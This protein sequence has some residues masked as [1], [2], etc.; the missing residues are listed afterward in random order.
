MTRTVAGDDIVSRS[1]NIGRGNWAASE[2][3]PHRP[4][5]WPLRPIHPPPDRSACARVRRCRA[6]SH[7]EGT[8]PPGLE[9]DAPEPR[10]VEPPEQGR[11]LA[12]PQVSGTSGPEA[13]DRLERAVRA[14]P[15]V[16]PGGA[17]AADA[18]V[19]EREVEPDGVGR[20]ERAQTPRH[21]LGRAPGEV[22]APREP[23]EAADAVHVRVERHDQRAARHVPEA[24]VDPVGAAHHPAQE[25][26]EPLAGAPARGVREEVLEPPRRAALPEQWSEIG[27]AQLV[28]E[29]AQRDPQRPRRPPPRGEERAQ[30]SV[31]AHDAA[32]AVE[33]AGNVARSRHP[34]GEIGAAP[35]QLGGRGVARGGTRRRT[36]C[37]Q[38]RGEPGLE[39]V[40]APV[41]ERGAEQ[42]GHLDVERIRVT[43]H[44]LDRIAPQP[45]GRVGAP[46]QFLQRGPDQRGAL[47]LRGLRH[48]DSSSRTCVSSGRISFSQ[49]SLTAAGLPGMANT[50]SPL[51]SWPASARDSMAALPI[52]SYESTRNSSPNP[53]SGRTTARERASKVESRLDRPVPPVTS[54]NCAPEACARSSSAAMR[55]GS[56]G[57]IAEPVTACPAAASC[58]RRMRPPSSVASVRESEQ[59]TTDSLALRGARA[60]CAPGTPGRSCPCSCPCPWSCSCPCPCFCPT[61]SSSRSS[62]RPPS[63]RTGKARWSWHSRGIVTLRPVPSSKQYSWHGQTTARLRAS[64]QPPERRHPAW[65]HESSIAVTRP[66]WQASSTSLSPISSPRSSP[67]TRSAGPTSIQSA[68]RIAYH[69]LV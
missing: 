45:R 57:T 65:L 36:Q 32:G 44:Q 53:G 27:R 35:Q 4:A 12:L 54:A 5:F 47:P 22:L 49:A 1:R 8:H 66:P 56:S 69:E 40:D 58:S 2:I 3:E 17:L 68:T 33:Q 67:S 24:E 42:T 34:V 18:E 38:Q 55:C 30:G 46:E 37:A 61:Y 52:S 9:K 28:D 25:Q 26:V 48:R 19:A 10:T 15:V 11:V 31:R 29:L 20:V 6:P 43:V 63:I 21:F 14:A 16:P 23:D 62:T 51:P 39:E 41:G 59:V 50:N 13:A 60:L 64:S 7:R